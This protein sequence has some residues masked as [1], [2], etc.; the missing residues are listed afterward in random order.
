M[1]NPFFHYVAFP[2]PVVWHPLANR[3]D[4]DLVPCTCGHNCKSSTRS[5]FGRHR[6]SSIAMET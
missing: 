1:A 5:L 4:T 3:W 6:I 2:I